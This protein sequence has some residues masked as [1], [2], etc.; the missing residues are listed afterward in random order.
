MASESKKPDNQ[1]RRH[2]FT[3]WCPTQDVV[4][5]SNE[6]RHQVTGLLRD[7]GANKWV[8]Q[9][10]RGKTSKKL[11]FQGRLH[12]ERKIRASTL[13]RDIEELLG[14]DSGAVHMRIEANEKGSFKYCMKDDTRVAGPWA[15]HKIVTYT[16]WRIKRVE[17][18]PL[19]WQTTI[20]EALKVPCRDDIHIDWLFD[21]EGVK[22]KT[23]LM[24][25]LEV[26][27]IATPLPFLSRVDQMAGYLTK[28]HLDTGYI[29][30]IPRTVSEKFDWGSFYAFIECLKQGSMRGALF[31]KATIWRA[32]PPHVWVTSNRL[33]AFGALSGGRLRVHTIVNSELKPWK[34]PTPKVFVEEDGI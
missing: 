17:D 9:L 32:D 5:A 2:A 3:L 10:E 8:F 24:D 1:Q 34:L 22:G 15:D 7:I 33:P 13:A 30:D 16:G 18:S 29:I 11:H 25:Y 6:F 27:E 4:V 26:H 21:P 20:I 23:T 14:L 19:R 31:G 28:V 12:L